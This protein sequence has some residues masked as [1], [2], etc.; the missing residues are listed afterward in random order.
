MD[1]LAIIVCIVFLYSDYTLGSEIN[2]RKKYGPEI[3]NK[4]I[5]Y[6]LQ[7]GMSDEKVLD[8]GNLIKKGCNLTIGSEDDKKNRLLSRDIEINVG[9]NII[10]IC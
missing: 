6:R 10:Q 7:A 5:K 1:K 2:V 9:K 3:K 8:N 4:V